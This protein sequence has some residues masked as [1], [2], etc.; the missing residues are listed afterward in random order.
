M[1]LAHID[2]NFVIHL[3]SC[4]ELFDSDGPESVTF[5]TFLVLTAIS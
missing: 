5:N 3:L 2:V 4:T 1:L